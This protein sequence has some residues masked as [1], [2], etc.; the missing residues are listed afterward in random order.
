MKKI[1]IILIL[2][3]VSFESLTQPNIASWSQKFDAYQKAN[4]KT[5]LHLILNQNKFSPG[6]TAWFKAYFLTENLIGIE[7][8]QLIDLNLVD[9]NGNSKLHFL[10]RVENG[11]GHNQLVIPDTLSAGVY[12][13]TAHSSGMKD[14]DPAQI[15][16]K[17]IV[18]VTDNKIVLNEKQTLKITPEGG[19]L[20]RDV[21]NKLSIHSSIA[22]STILIIDSEEIEIARVSTDM[23]GIGS[24]KF[25]PKLNKK[26]YA[27]IIGDTIRAPL[28]EIK[29]DGVSLLLETERKGESIKII[30]TSPQ[31]SELRDKELAVIV[32]ARNKV[33][34]S[35]TFRQGNQNFVEIQ[36]PQIE[37]PDGI[38]HACVLDN[39]AN[40]LASRDFYNHRDHISASIDIDKKNFLPREKIIFE[41]SITDDKGMPLVGEFVVNV[42]NTATQEIENQNS[43]SDELNIL[44]G[45]SDAYVI[46]RSDSAWLTSLD[47]YLISGTKD[48]SWKKI[49]TEKIGSPV[50][51]YSRIIQKKGRA[52]FADTSKPLPPSTHIMFY[53]QNGLDRYQ[54]VT[55]ENGRFGLAMLDVV[56]KDEFFYIAESNGEEIPDI[57]IVWDEIQLNL[58]HA[59]SWSEIGTPDLYA[60][61]VQ[62][63]RIIDQSYNIHYSH[64]VFE[65][66]IDEEEETDEFENIIKG[67]DIS[68]N[69]QDYVILSSMEELV[70]EVIPSIFHRKTG[71]KSIVRVSL[72]QPMQS[73]HDPLY[74]IDGIAT[75]NTDFFLS[76]KP[77]DLL[78]VKVVYNPKKLLPLGLMGK[79][80]IVIV[81]SKS[82]DIREPINDSTRL[83]EGVNKPLT[84]ATKNYSEN[85]ITSKPD[86]RSSIYWNPSIKTDERGKAL[87]EFYCSDDIG[88][89]LIKID[90]I[91]EKGK[92]FTATANVMVELPK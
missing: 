25:I 69:V 33:Y 12:L 88:N 72:M 85:Q 49:L 84:F 14:F 16:M 80:G 58:P 44:Y 29:S 75:K 1:L 53:L 78:S 47:N 11:L 77:A 26:Y 60:S 34:Y 4:P 63:K 24:V 68:I 7:G 23:Q 57:K 91:A 92:P 18:I 81:H 45:K 41:I 56:G 20:V 9:V 2:L 3:N 32:S 36:V 86:F 79:D 87:V 17:E 73:R 62:K 28:S 13:I 76:L 30:A 35:T 74:I 48:I 55:A 70:K 43:L 65:T 22:R 83:V 40:L 5:K 6:D 38:V 50:Y 15:F 39:A 51:P 61:F 10:F 66:S 31:G 52:Y 19:R 27:T 59:P 8:K 64:G 82:G 89:L 21:Q 90:G 46:D 37:L 54:T 67:A 42:L 71:K